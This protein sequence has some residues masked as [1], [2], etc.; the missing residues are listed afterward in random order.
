MRRRRWHWIGL[1]IPYLW[2]VAAIPWVNRVDY[3]P[4]GLPFLFVWML[5]GIVVISGCI[6]VV[7]AIDRRWG[8]AALSGDGE[9]S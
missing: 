7:F 2:D 1:L 4:L 5:V 6:A 3:E 9:G 8:K